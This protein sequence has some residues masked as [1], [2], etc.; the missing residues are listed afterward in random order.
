VLA[1]FTGAKDDGDGGDNW[2]YKSCKA[3]VKSSPPTNQHPTFYRP[4]VLPT[5][6][7]NSVKALKRDTLTNIIWTHK[8]KK[9][10]IF[11][12]CFSLL[13]AMF[14]DYFLQHVYTIAIYFLTSFTMSFVPNRCLNST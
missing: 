3:L 13:T 9:I 12:C 8:N 5:N 11:I 1:C 2:S 14:W 10:Y 7:T 4:D 6:P